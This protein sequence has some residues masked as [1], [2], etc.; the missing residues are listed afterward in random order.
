MK[1]AARAPAQSKSYVLVPDDLEVESH[2]VWAD[3][4]VL[5]TASS[6]TEA[7]QLSQAR[8]ATEGSQG[9]QL[10]LRVPTYI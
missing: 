9:R 7:W 5:R 10:E 3:L 2:R 6:I 1:V 8:R 4:D